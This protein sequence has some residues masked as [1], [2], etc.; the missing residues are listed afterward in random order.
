MARLLQDFFELLA[1][2]GSVE[3]VDG[4]VKP[5]VLFAF[6]DE[7]RQALCVR[8]EMPGLRDE[9]NQQTPR[10]INGSLI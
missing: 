10:A 1:D 3:T 4:D 2:D 6:H 8:R 5:V 7:I 9:M